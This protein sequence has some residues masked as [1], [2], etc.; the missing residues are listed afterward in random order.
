MILLD[1]LTQVFEKHNLGI[2]EDM[3]QAVASDVDDMLE[4]YD[5]KSSWSSEAKEL[6]EEALE[7]LKD[8]KKGAMS[9]QD[10]VE[11]G[12]L[13]FKIEELNIKN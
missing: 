4:D 7:H 10:R 6:L 2:S 9:E 8:L 5:L 12:V 3:A 1:V 11:L 13:I